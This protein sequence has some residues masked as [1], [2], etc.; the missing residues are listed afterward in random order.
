[1]ACCV[2]G[3]GSGTAAAVSILLN[4]TISETSRDHILDVQESLKEHGVRI[5]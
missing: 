3:Q 2:T 5:Y 4:K 1:M